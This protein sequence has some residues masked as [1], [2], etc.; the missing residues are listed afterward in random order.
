[1]FLL[2]FSLESLKEFISYANS[3]L[4]KEIPEGDY[5]GLVECM[6]YLMKVKQRQAATGQS[7][8]IALLYAL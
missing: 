3:G 1:M 6:A 7:T 8:I 4:E 5:H 2:L